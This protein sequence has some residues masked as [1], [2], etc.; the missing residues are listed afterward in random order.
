VVLDKRQPLRHAALERL[1][2]VLR[3]REGGITHEAF[4][5]EENRHGIVVTRDEPEHRL[6][7]DPGLA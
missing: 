1:Q 6:A 4:V 5:I 7:V 2:L 3:Q